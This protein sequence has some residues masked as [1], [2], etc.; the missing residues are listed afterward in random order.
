MGRDLLAN[1]YGRFYYLPSCLAERG[2]EIHHLLLDYRNGEAVDIERNGMRWMSEPLTLS[3]GYLKKLQSVVRAVRPDWIIGCS[4]T[5]FGILAQHY[6]CKHGMRSCIDAYDN[7][8]SYMPWMLPLHMLWR[9]AL[10]RADLIT[11][12]GPGLLAYMSAGRAGKPAAVVPM[13]ADPVG[14][15]PLDRTECRRKLGLPGSRQLVGYCGSLHRSRGVKVLFD[16]YEMLLQQH[17]DVGLVLSGR[18]WKNQPA[19][20]YATSLGYIEDELMPHLLNSMNVLTI[21]NRAS[22]F[23]NHSHPVKLYEAMRCGVPVVATRTPATEWILADNQ[24]CLADPGDPQDLCRRLAASLEASA[25]VYKGITDW[26][27]SA[28]SFEQ[29]LLEAETKGS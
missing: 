4:D 28:C 5:Y 20:G 18:Q 22:R 23:G 19:P 21:I 25:P 13:A 8:E 11:A 14:F 3:G 15:V 6:A 27:G 24:E 2:H 16:A 7:Y 9:R 12:A 26:Q 17:P 29:A 1:P 10:A